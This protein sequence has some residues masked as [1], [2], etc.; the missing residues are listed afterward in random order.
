[1]DK[2]VLGGLAAGGAVIAGLSIYWITGRK[3]EPPLEPAPQSAV[4]EP[5][6]AAAPPPTEAPKP[7][8]EAQK[9]QPAAPRKAPAPKAKAPGAVSATAPKPEPKPVYSGPREG[10]VLWSGELIKGGRIIMLPGLPRAVRSAMT[11]RVS[12]S[13]SESI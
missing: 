4:S 9:K 8:P 12:R 5:V 2:K 11:F 13:M 10:V 3:P 1:M 7:A 6:P